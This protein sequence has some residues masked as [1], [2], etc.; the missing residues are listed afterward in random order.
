MSKYDYFWKTMEL[1]DWSREGDDMLVLEPVIEYLS[2]QSDEK[3]YGF[4]DQMNELLDALD[5]R[6]LAEQCRQAYEQANEETFLYSRCVALINGPEYYEKTSLGQNSDIWTKEFEAVLYVPCKAWARKHGQDAEEYP[7]MPELSRR[8]LK[9]IPA[10]KAEN[11]KPR[12]TQKQKRVG[13]IRKQI[14]LS[15]VFFSLGM[16]LAW[17]GFSRLG[18][19]FMYDIW[20]ESVGKWPVYLLLGTTAGGLYLTIKYV[21]EKVEKGAGYNNMTSGLQIIKLV[22]CVI[23]LLSPVLFIVLVFYRFYQLRKLVNMESD[24]SGQRYA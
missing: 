22:Y 23:I 3:I 1:C 16:L 2:R 6:M 12:P 10:N 15:L 11:K 14:W 4:H 24:D 13:E 17:F 9:D 7:H 21:S 18:D 8:T 20:N 19:R 5:T